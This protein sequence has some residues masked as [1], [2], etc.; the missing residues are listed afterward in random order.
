MEIV[1]PL[2]SFPA[3]TAID[4]DIRRQLERGKSVHPW[5]VQETLEELHRRKYFPKASKKEDD[6]SIE[7]WPQVLRAVIEGGAELALSSFGAVLFY[8]Q[9]SL[10]DFEVL[11]SKYSVVAECED[12]SVCRS[13]L[14]T[15]CNVFAQWGR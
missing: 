3:S 4:A 8:L 11:S 6:R 14:L 13:M 12:S 2:E 5:D 9:R 15:I 1:K 10:I 7:R